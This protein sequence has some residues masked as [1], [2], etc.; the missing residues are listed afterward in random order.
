MSTPL[1]LPAPAQISAFLE[2]KLHKKSSTPAVSSS[3]VPVLSPKLLHSGVNPHRSTK[4]ALGKI[5]GAKSKL[6]NP[7][8]NVQA[9]LTW[10]SSIICQSR[11]LP[12]ATPLLNLSSKIPGSLLTPINSPNLMDSLPMFYCAAGTVRAQGSLDA[13]HQNVTFY[14]RFFSINYVT[15][16][17]L[18][19]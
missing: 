11:R 18:L 17:I 6:L 10:P 13:K 19:R 2:A 16:C 3:S 4:T 1:T 5:A 14:G 7:K 8:A 15:L 12:P 9:P